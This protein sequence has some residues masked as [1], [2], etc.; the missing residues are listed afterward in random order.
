MGSIARRF[1]GAVVG[2]ALAT[3]VGGITGLTIAAPALAASTTFVANT[4][5]NLRSGP[6]TSY[7]II[8]LIPDG[9]TMSGNGTPSGSWTPVVYNGKSGYVWS[10]YVTAQASAAVTTTAAPAPAASTSTA[11]TTGDVNVRTGPGTSYSIVGVA[12]EGTTVPV[13]GTTSGG[14]TQVVWNGT[15][16]W[17]YTSYLSV[18]LAAPPAS[19]PTPAP[20]APTTPAPTTSPKPT[21][22]TATITG[23]VRTTTD[24]NMRTDGYYGAPV[25]GQLPANVV[26]DVTGKTTSTYTQ[27]VYQ[28]R[29]LWIYT[30]YTTPVSTTPT[31]STSATKS[32]VNAQEAQIVAYAKAHLG[33]PY[34][35]N[36][37]GPDYYDCAGLVAAAYRSAGYPM[38]YSEAWEISHGTSVSRSELTPG[39]VI[40]W[41]APGHESVAI[42]I[43]ND[44]IV[45]ADGPSYGIRTDTITHRL[46]W[47][48]WGD[49]R[50]YV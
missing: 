8:T 42:Y 36:T 17:I 20:T 11:V 16:R 28:G 21:T 22:S 18:T 47:D 14:W 23:Q 26:V 10:D 32:T 30:A 37:M 46:T 29:L 50:H 3:S 1:K 2:L 6:G 38:V 15:N 41:A 13:T 27:I 39:D 4:S 45:I 43:G 33:Y 35:V 40:Y 48:T 25:Y 7:A 12:A 34:R 5:V 44:T 9:G 19:T 31:T 24:V 49:A